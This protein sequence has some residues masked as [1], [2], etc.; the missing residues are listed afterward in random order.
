MIFLPA[1]VCRGG[2]NYRQRGEF[3]PIYKQDGK[4]NGLQK[5]RVIVSFT[6]RNGEYRQ[7][8]RTTYG[9]EE[10]KQLETELRARSLEA[11]SGHLTVDELIAEYLAA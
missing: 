4:K 10:A 11:A 3:M 9:R 8:S 2:R 5:Y 6:D 1:P 7:I